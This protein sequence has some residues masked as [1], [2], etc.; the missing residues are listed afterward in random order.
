MAA[1]GGVALGLGNQRADPRRGLQGSRSGVG[2]I[3]P[4]EQFFAQ[5]MQ[6]G[7]VLERCGQR[8]PIKLCKV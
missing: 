2:P 5:T 6:D 3:A 1:D 8:C 7:L 4:H